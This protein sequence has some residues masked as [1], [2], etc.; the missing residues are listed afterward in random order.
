[1]SSEF[2]ENFYADVS[3]FSVFKFPSL[4][5][6][7]VFLKNNHALFPDFSVIYTENQTAGRGRF[8][9]KWVSSIGKGL[10]FS[11]KIPLDQIPTQNWCNITQ[12]MALAIAQMLEDKKIHSKM[13]WPNDIIVEGVKICGILGEV[14]QCSSKYSMVLGVGLNVNESKNDFFTIDRKATSLSLIT[15]IEFIP[16][17]ILEVVLNKFINCYEKLITYGYKSLLDEL[18][19]RL[20]RSDSPVKVLSGNEEY[21][22]LI[23]GLTQDG[24]I[25]LKTATG[26]I[27]VQSGEITSRV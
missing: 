27:E 7:N 25:Q 26:V 8:D 24:R 14:V 18:E 10:T 23:A 3:N 22:G 2:S 16:G 1:M 5:S 6:T 21:I 20:Y 13:R 15:G 11:I 12:V 19:K 9:R 4:D 17:D